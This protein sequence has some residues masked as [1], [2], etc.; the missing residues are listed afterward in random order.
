MASAR[1]GASRWITTRVASG[2]MS[3]GVIPVPPVVNTRSQRSST[4]WLSRSSM[5]EKSSGT[6]S[7][8]AISHPAFSASAAS[9]GP[10]RSSASRRETEVE[11]MRMAVLMV[12]S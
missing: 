5:S 11:T 3:S 9:T 4:K 1:P 7:I 8:W 12:G 6:T 10:E 2:V